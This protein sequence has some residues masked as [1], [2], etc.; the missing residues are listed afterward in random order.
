MNRCFLMMCIILFQWRG[1]FAQIPKPYNHYDV[2]FGKHNKKL[3]EEASNIV[4]IFLDKD[5]NYYPEM[6]INDRD[7]RK[8]HNS[9]AEWY[10]ENVDEFGE[11]CVINN[12]AT[13]TFEEKLI[14]LNDALALKIANNINARNENSY[15]VNVSIHGFSKKAYGV[16]I[17]NR[18]A[19]GDN[20][21]LEAALSQKAKGKLF[22]V[23][24]YWD[25]KYIGMLQ[26]SILA[27]WSYIFR[28]AA[29][30]NAMNVGLSLRK[31]I[32]NIANQHINIITH[33]LGARVACELL[34]NAEDSNI[35]RQHSIPTPQQAH[36]KL[37]MI[38]PAICTGLFKNYWQRIPEVTK[39]V[40]DN[41]SI[42][43]VYNTNDIA[44]N[45]S[46]PFLFFHIGN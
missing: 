26:G 37:C 11:L 6:Y 44:L 15:L 9:L 41:Y 36:I 16:R 20:K 2:T 7:L 12:I 25:A 23:E 3:P 22:F 5:G 39:P 27:K 46:M 14:K 43:V 32:S 34:F 19:S 33:S 40:N 45:K 13:G 28:D 42:S 29:M 30:P 21:K 4:R 17:M 24:V 1:S 31:V 8:C 18:L 38:A 35:A 10:A